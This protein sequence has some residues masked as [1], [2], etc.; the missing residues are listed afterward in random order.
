MLTLLPIEWTRPASANAPREPIAYEVAG[1]AGDR[2]AVISMAPS[3]WRLVDELLT[4]KTDPAA[5]YS[6]PE[7]ALAALKAAVEE[8]ERPPTF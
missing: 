1:L 2:R 7:E 5:R 6:T 3:G 4:D 8:A